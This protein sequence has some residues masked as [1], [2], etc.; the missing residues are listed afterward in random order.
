M[1]TVLRRRGGAKLQKGIMKRP[2][3]LLAAAAA[4]LSRSPAPSATAQH[5]HVK[6]MTF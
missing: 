4:A 6:Y 1:A 2:L 3:L 5:Q